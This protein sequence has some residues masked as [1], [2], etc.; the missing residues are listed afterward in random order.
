M[1]V[2]DSGPGILPAARPHLFDRFF[3][4]KAEGLGLGL[5]LCRESIEACGGSIRADTSG[6]PGAIFVIELVDE[7]WQGSGGED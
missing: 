7:S 1:T 5:A 2:K 4:T 6:E 3:T